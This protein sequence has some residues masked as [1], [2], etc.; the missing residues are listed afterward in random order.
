M[1]ND[2]SV[3]SNDQQN[4]GAFTL[5]RAFGAPVAGSVRTY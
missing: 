3:I 2:E 1:K 5:G 4:L